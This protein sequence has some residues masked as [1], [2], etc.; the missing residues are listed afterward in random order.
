VV[1]KLVAAGQTGRKARAGFY[2]WPESPKVPGPVRRFVKRPSRVVNAA[3]YGMVGGGARRGFGEREI[4]DRLALLFV[5]EAIRCLEEGVLRSASD[6][7]LGAVLG[8][9]FPPFKGG[10]FHFADEMGLQL[11][12]DKL[13]ALAAQHGRRYEPAGL[14]VERARTGQPFF[15]E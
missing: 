15:G 6:G 9:G 4:Q 11:L 8:L 13:S 1:P 2:L 3:V 12:T 5:N 14:L 7:D 10:P